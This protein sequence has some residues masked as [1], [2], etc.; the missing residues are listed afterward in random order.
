MTQHEYDIVQTDE[1]TGVQMQMYNGRYGL[2]SMSRGQNDVWYKVW[3]FLSK[4]SNQRPVPDDKK[5]PMS[6]RIGGDKAE[7]QTTLKELL[8]QL[9]D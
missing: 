7:A 6:V 8:R 2:L 3:C 4:W 1:Y 9:N 5:R